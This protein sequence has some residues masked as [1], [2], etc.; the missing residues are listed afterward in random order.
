MALQ[1]V[2]PW[3]AGWAG[4]A[5][6]GI[7]MLIG[8]GGCRLGRGRVHRGRRHLAEGALGQCGAGQE[9]QGRERAGEGGEL[10]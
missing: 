2:P 1:S 7:G 8:G 10:G 9:R 4:A 3:G 6:E 5:A